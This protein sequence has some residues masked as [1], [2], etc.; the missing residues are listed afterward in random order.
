[1]TLID[2][3]CP[4]SL[5]FLRCELTH[6]SNDPMRHN[7]KIKDLLNEKTFCVVVMSLPQQLKRLPIRVAFHTPDS[8]LGRPPPVHLRVNHIH[9]HTYMFLPS[10]W[11]V[12]NDS[13]TSTGYCR[14]F[15]ILIP[16]I[17]HS[18]L[19]LRV[20]LHPCFCQTMYSAGP[21]S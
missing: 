10:E 7:K 8:Y 2:E 21:A 20:V 1:M 16:N 5:G 19:L 4:P 9:L 6:K 12:P 15:S 13:R 3:M 18:T 11:N 14:S 17:L